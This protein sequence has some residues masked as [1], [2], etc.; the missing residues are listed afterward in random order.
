MVRNRNSG[1]CKGVGRKF[2]RG[3]Q[4]KKR[5][6]ISKKYRIALLSLFQGRERGTKKRPKIALLRLYL[7]YLYHVSKSRGATAPLPSAADAYG[8][9]VRRCAVR[10]R[11]P[12]GAEVR[13]AELASRC[14][15]PPLRL[16]L[17]VF[18][19]SYKCRT[20]SYR[21][22]VHCPACL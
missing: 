21:L 13:G 16:R 12:D 1:A 20:F 17:Q 7:L 4:L 2:S 5:Q 9:V 6:K 19:K 18:K 8:C 11:A 10:N 15:C 22:L 14:G 3:G